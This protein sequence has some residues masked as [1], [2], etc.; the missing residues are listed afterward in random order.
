MRAG[1]AL[2]DQGRRL[3][4]EVSER[5]RHEGFDVRVGVHTGGVLLSGGVGA[6]AGIRGMPVNVAARMEQTA[7]AGTLRISH[8]TYRHVRGVFDVEPQPPMVVKGVDEP[9]ATYLVCGAKPRAFRVPT[10]GIEGVETRMIGRDAELARLQEA[11][12]SLYAERRLAIVT[13]V[14]EAGV[15]K[16][17]LLYEFDN[18]TETRPEPSSSSRAGRCRGPSANPTDCCATSSPGASRSATATRWTSPRR[19]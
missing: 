9:V 10:R 16:S 3:A 19:R 1:L 11:F 4:A 15:G 14:A 7:P 6:E 5:Y 18:W 8:A 2:L 17:R 13:V 12:T